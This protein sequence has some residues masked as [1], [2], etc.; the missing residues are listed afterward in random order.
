IL[1][2]SAT[3]PRL[4][5]RHPVGHGARLRPGDLHRVLYAGAGFDHHGA[6]AHH[7]AQDEGG[8]HSP[9]AG[10]GKGGG[11]AMGGPGGAGGLGGA[12]P[13]FNAGTLENGGGAGSSAG[14]ATGGA[15]SSAGGAVGGSSPA[16]G[17]VGGSGAPSSGAAPVAAK[18]RPTSN[19]H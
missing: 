8:D 14:G 12:R 16:T 19:S 5:P 1:P 7:P 18:P 3:P 15:G 4:R 2:L 13:R 17:A 11:G 10:R 6:K 9:R